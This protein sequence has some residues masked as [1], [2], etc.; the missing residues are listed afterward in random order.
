MTYRE[1]VAQC[2]SPDVAGL[3][4][5]L[6]GEGAVPEAAY[7]H[8]LTCCGRSCR[9][10]T[11]IISGATTSP[12]VVFPTTPL[13]AAPIGD[14]ETVEL[15]GARV[16]TFPTFI[17]NTS[18]G[19]VAGHP[20]HQPAGGDDARPACR[21]ASSS[22]VPRAAMRAARDRAAVEAVLPPMPAPK[23]ERRCRD[24]RPPPRS[25]AAPRENQRTR[26]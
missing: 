17:R 11:A 13:P 5:S 14:D 18:P 10:R 22:T 3:L 7:R 25:S 26:P 9:P 6:H 12:R 23:A 1:L 21:S 15:N 19:S 16:P 20:R 2:A 4:Q 24:F 8:A